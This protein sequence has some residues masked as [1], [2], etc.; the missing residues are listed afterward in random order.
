M[1]TK[2]ERPDEVSD[3]AA[4]LV[5]QKWAGYAVFWAGVC[6]GFGNLACGVCVGICGSGCALADAQNGN[7]FVKV[8]VDAS[9]RQAARV[10]CLCTSRRGRRARR[11]LCRVLWARAHPCT[12]KVHGTGSLVPYRR[13]QPA[14]LLTRHLTRTAADLSDRDLRLRARHLRHH[15]VHECEI[16]ALVTPSALQW[17]RH[18]GH[19]FVIP[20]VGKYNEPSSVQATIRREDA[21]VG[22]GAVILGSSS[23]HD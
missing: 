19:G 23:L 14:A 10:S 4:L 2:I 12:S 6:C 1:Q 20:C 16:C 22:L 11:V 17:R 21:R 9:A 13:Q 15:H 7:L 3:T 8:R 5:N 18:G